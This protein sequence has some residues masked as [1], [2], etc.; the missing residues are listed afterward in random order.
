MPSASGAATN[1]SRDAPP[2]ASVQI[3]V[4]TPRSPVPNRRLRRELYDILKALAWLQTLRHHVAVILAEV[5][6]HK[7]T[8]LEV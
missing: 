5:T 7:V 1:L 4:L 8:S 3:A 6:L 2:N